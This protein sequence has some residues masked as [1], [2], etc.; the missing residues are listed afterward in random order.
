MTLSIF[1]TKII[2]VLFIFT[3]VVK[4]CISGIALKMAA[5]KDGKD[6]GEIIRGQNFDVG[7]RY[8]NLDY[9]GE[10]AYGMVV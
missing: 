2:N 4:F 5:S 3:I 1:E 9:I 8:T 6:L 10:G 7:P